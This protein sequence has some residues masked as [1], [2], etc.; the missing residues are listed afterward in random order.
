MYALFLPASS[1][2]NIS[3]CDTQSV[4]VQ[5]DSCICALSSLLVAKKN[6]YHAEQARVRA[7]STHNRNVYAPH[8]FTNTSKHASFLSLTPLRAL[9]EQQALMYGDFMNGAVPFAQIFDADWS[10]CLR[11]P[12]FVHEISLMWVCLCWHCPV[13]FLMK[14]FFSAPTWLREQTCN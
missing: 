14:Y 5:S 4:I 12:V 3:M 11:L 7:K 6:T 2:T 13:G 10:N 8:T 9:E 1:R